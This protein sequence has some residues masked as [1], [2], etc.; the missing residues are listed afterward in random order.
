VVGYDAMLRETVEELIKSGFN[1]PILCSSTLTAPTWQPRVPTNGREIVTV[2]P[3]RDGPHAQ[4]EENVVFVFSRITLN[5]ALRCASQ[6]RTTREFAL[7]WQRQGDNE[8]GIEAHHLVD[9]DAI[10]PMTVTSQW[11]AKDIR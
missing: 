2:V 9:G 4:A 5:R 6:S 11:R 8:G 7:R 10:I 1:G 3:H